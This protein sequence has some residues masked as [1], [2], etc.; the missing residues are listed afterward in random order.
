M[1]KTDILEMLSNADLARIRD[2]AIMDS[3]IETA[4]TCVEMLANR[5][6]ARMTASVIRNYETIMKNEQWRNQ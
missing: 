3:D 5:R 1:K 4:Q 2:A 6:E